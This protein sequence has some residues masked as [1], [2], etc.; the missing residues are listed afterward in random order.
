MFRFV[1]LFR[2]ER[3]GTNKILLLQIFSN[4]RDPGYRDSTV[5]RNFVFLYLTKR[6]LFS[7]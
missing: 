1:E 6:F 4:C 5:L 3:K 7:T 2:A